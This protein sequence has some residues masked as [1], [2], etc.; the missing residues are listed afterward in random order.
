M[1]PQLEQVERVACYSPEVAI[2]D[3]GY[4]GKRYVNDT[5]IFTPKLLPQSASR[6]QKQK[7]RERFRSRAGI[8]PVISHIKHDHRMM[9]N[10][11]SGLMGDKVNTIMAATAFNLKKM[12]NK[13]KKELENIFFNFAQELFQELFHF[14]FILKFQFLKKATL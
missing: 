3:R 2:V 11:L 12:L 4:R 13:I 10:Y 9:R 7:T 1:E 14:I 8:E 5:M 6:Y